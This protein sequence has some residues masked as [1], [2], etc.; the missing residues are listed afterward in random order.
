MN[1]EHLRCNAKA[2][3]LC[4]PVFLKT[5]MHTL[6]NFG[7]SAFQNHSA[8]L[9]MILWPRPFPKEF[10]Q[11]LRQNAFQNRSA[12]SCLGQ[13]ALQ[14]CSYLLDKS[15]NIFQINGVYMI[16]QGAFQNRSFLCHFGQGA[17]QTILRP[18]L[19]DLVALLYESSRRKPG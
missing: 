8:Q 19:D 10:L 16:S 14:I 13:G 4:G 12:L 1:F 3:L 5:S 15:K 18:L 9:F 7:Q 11:D 17:S 6:F 2:C